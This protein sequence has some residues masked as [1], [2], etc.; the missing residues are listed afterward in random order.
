MLTRQL[1]VLTAV[2]TLLGTS[3]AAGEEVRYYEKDGVTYR[4]THQIIQR[5]IPQVTYTE[6]TQTVYRDQ[7]VTTTKDTVRTYWTP[8]TEYRIQQR[9]VGRWNPFIQPYFVYENVPTVRWEARREVVPV[10]TTSRQLVPATRIVRTPV[11]TWRTVQEEVIS[12]VAVSANPSTSS[13]LA[14]VPSRSP[15][16][17][18]AGPLVPVRIPESARRDAVGGLSRLDNDP[19]RQ[20]TSTAW[21]SSD[22]RLQR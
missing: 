3:L 20:G 6:Q 17:V 22:D 14:S 10:Q 5:Q 15:N 9:L 13:T 18:E 21:R 12:R 4:E 8:V 2:T 7:C 1:V 19:P 16:I 11:T